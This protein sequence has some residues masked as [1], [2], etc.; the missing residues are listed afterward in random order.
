M[1]WGDVIAGYSV[2]PVRVMP[3][4]AGSPKVFSP[5]AKKRKGPKKLWI[6]KRV[7]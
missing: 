5:R 2:E 6:P 3:L 1:W 4:Y 7:L